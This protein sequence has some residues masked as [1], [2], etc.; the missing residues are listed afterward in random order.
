MSKPNKQSFTIFIGL[1]AAY[2]LA[3]H[4]GQPGTFHTIKE[5]L[6]EAIKLHYA[7]PDYD[8]KYRANVMRQLTRK[9]KMDGK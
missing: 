2:R 1:T 9:N 4:K 5:A 7:S 8:D 6:L 3:F